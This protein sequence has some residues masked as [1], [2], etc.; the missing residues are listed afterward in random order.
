MVAPEF[1][2]EFQKIR[3]TFGEYYKFIE[4]DIARYSLSLSHKDL[5]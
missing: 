2:E 3:E 1:L 4:N 5:T